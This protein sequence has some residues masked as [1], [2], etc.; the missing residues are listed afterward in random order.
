M[1]CECPF[2]PCVRFESLLRPSVLTRRMSRRSA[3]LP[4]ID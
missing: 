4:T 2:V 3:Q 1:V